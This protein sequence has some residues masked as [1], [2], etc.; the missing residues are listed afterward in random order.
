MARAYWITLYRE[1]RRPDALTAYAKL[2][3]PALQAAGGRM[4]ARG[5]PAEVHE[6][7]IAQR[8]VLIE[9]DSLEKAR[10]AYESPAYREALAALGDAVDRDI[11]FIEGAD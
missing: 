6:G 8:T 9:F 7:G 11:R 5:M 4:L 10:A 3:G 1:V 2:A